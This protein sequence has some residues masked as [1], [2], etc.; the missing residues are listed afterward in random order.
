MD[1]KSKEALKST[2][3]TLLEQIEDL[4]TSE[5]LE[6]FAALRIRLLS[7]VPIMDER[8]TVDDVEEGIKT[9]AEKNCGLGS[10]LEAILERETNANFHRQNFRLVATLD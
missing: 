2:V 3:A 1:K 7:I 8:M 6:Y 4:E 5:T 9:L 10:E